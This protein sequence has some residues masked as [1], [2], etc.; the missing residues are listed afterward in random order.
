M[1]FVNYVNAEHCDGERELEC[2][3]CASACRAAGAAQLVQR[4]WCG[5]NY[6]VKCEKVD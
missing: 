6:V 2:D 5:L 4:G 3:G 1:Y